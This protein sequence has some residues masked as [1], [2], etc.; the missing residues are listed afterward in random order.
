MRQIRQMAKH[1]GDQ[2]KVLMTRAPNGWVGTT[3]H[4]QERLSEYAIGADVEITLHQRRSNRHNSMY[5]VVLSLCVANSEGKYGSSQDLH[6]MLKVCLG[7]S[8]KVRLLIPSARAEQA[9]VLV[10]VLLVCKKWTPKTQ[11][12]QERIDQ[13]IETAKEFETD[14]ENIVLPGS[15]AFDEMDQAGFRIYFDRAM[16]QLRLADYPVDAY[17]KESKKQLARVRPVRSGPHHKDVKDGLP[18]GQEAA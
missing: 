16:D 17:M 7:Y 4:D 11:W 5:W 9:S 18:Q 2:P 6:R 15:T 3:A 8:R 10:R 14:C 12:L 1:S 13:A